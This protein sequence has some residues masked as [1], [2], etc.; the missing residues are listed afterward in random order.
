LSTGKPTIPGILQDGLTVYDYAR[1]QLGYTPD[2][3]IVYGESI[4]TA[5]TCYIATNR[6]CA[7]VVLQSGIGS[8]PAV[9]RSLLPFLW[10]FPD[11]IFAEPH[12]DN[13][14]LVHQIHIPILFCHG[15]IDRIVPCNE[16]KKMFANANEPK[17]LVILP[18]CG[19]NDMGVQNTHEF[20]DAIGRFVA[21][22]K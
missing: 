10:L 16:S 11:C 8:L 19:H 1:S 9:G 4:G 6:K 21:S 20:Y 12:L 13:V 3:I 18:D 7:A 5:V 15:A 22:V 17:Q 14:A 2:K